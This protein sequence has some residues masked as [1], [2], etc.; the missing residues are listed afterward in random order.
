M[1]NQPGGSPHAV[2]AFDQAQT[3]TLLGVF[4][5]VLGSLEIMADRAE[6]VGEPGIVE[7]NNTLTP[8]LESLL[9]TVTRARKR[10]PI[11]PIGQ[12]EPE[13]EAAY[14]AI[15]QA[16]EAWI[17]LT[18]FDTAQAAIETHTDG[19]RGATDDPIDDPGN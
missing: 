16:F 2:V 1:T 4:A 18:A 19:T 5:W 8:R 11:T 13:V 15:R 12:M 7:M 10:S 6:A 17:E 14:G 9:Q 3:G